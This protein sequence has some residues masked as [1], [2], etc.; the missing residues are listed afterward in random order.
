[1]PDLNDQDELMDEIKD[2]AQEF[3]QRKH[4]AIVPPV[5]GN[6][7][8]QNAVQPAVPQRVQPA[9]ALPPPLHLY[10]QHAEQQ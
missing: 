9:T 7:A 1:M 4:R 5:N 10:G 3:F 6:T 8:P 2:C